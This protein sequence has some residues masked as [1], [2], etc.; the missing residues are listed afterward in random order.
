MEQ[1]GR[2][3]NSSVHK[4]NIRQARGFTL[5]ELLV[6]I[7]IVAVL[8]VVVILTLNP[9][10]LLKQSR[11]SNR[12]SDLQ[13]MKRAISIYLVDVPTNNIWVGT[14]T[15]CY[16]HSSSAV[17]AAGCGTNRFSNAQLVATTSAAGFSSS[18]VGV[19]TGWVPVNLKAISS[20]APM[21]LW[22]KDPINNASYFYSYAP[23][24]TSL[25][26]ELNAEMESIKYGLSGS[27][28]VESTDGGN[29]SSTYEV[30]TAPG[31]SL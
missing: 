6:V 19:D 12:I 3:L 13:T 1:I 9:G 28:D 29:V 20:G 30:G 22:P 5:I 15:W 31:L 11:D 7:A 21:S 8:S 2:F 25:V 26:F 18:S 16:V 4:T 27:G 23:S 24:S 17:A 10:E 14:T